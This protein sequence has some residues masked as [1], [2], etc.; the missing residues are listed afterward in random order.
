M[1]KVCKGIQKLLVKRIMK[2]PTAE[3]KWAM[4]MNDMNLNWA[5]IY[6][7][8][9]KS[10]LSSKLRYFQFQLL[11]RYLPVNNFLF[12]LN[13]I[14]NNLCSFCKQD[15]ESFQHLFWDCGINNSFWLNVQN[16]ILKSNPNFC[17]KDILL[18]IMDSPSYIYNFVILHAKYYL[19]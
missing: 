3:I 17:K 13:I 4:Y 6:T 14:D 7:I 16:I 15:V 10:T 18:G 12:N 8:P 11:H 19:Y 5:E 9:L 2:P 1:D